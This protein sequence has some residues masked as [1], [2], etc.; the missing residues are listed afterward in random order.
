MHEDENTMP[1]YCP[2]QISIPHSCF[3]KLLKKKKE[4]FTNLLKMI[5]E[6]G[7]EKFINISFFE[8]KKKHVPSGLESFV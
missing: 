3:R 8:P 1:F 7:Y 5:E 2:K 4:D 6:E